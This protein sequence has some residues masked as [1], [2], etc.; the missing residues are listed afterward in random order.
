MS[1]LHKEKGNREFQADGGSI[2]T[3]PG[4]MRESHIWGTTRIS[5]GQVDRE[6]GQTGP[7][8]VRE[9]RLWK[10]G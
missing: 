6:W 9:A 8:E 5:E 1:S 4:G 7:G 3:M 10:V 2:F